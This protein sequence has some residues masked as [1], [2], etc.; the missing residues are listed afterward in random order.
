MVTAAVRGNYPLNNQTVL[1]ADTG[2][3]RRYCGTLNWDMIIIYFLFII[4]IYIYMII[5]S[6]RKV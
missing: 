2:N 3:A 6:Y 1:Y 5:A 4:I